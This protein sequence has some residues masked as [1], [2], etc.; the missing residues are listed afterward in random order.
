[1]IAIGFAGTAKNTGKTTTALAVLDQAQRAGLRLG[2]T[3]IGFDGET[4][5]H[6]TGLPK[7]RYLAPA[8]TWVTSA[9]DVLD[10]GTA[11]LQPIE[12]LD[13]STLFGPVVLAKVEQPGSLVLVGPN[14]K[15]GL[16]SALQRLEALGVDLA[17]VDGALNRL[18]LMAVCDGLVLSTG[19]AYDQRIPVIADHAYA[20]YR[21]F[22]L[23]VLPPTAETQDDTI[24]ITYPGGK[25]KILPGN[26]LLTIEAARDLCKLITTPVKCLEIPGVCAPDAVLQLIECGLSQ[27][28]G[29]QMV[30]RSTLNLVTGKDARTW[31]KV[32][33]RAQSLGITISIRESVP[34]RC[35]TVNPIFPEFTTRSGQ[36][37]Y[38]RLDADTLIEVVSERL[39]DIPV[40]NVMD[41][42]QPD[43]L[44]WLEI[45]LKG[46]KP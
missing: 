13:S 17:L 2:L 8:G 40:V 33:N 43:L 22:H 1:M 34:L 24:V 26:S 5:D 16:R 39:D 30:F 31:L 12:T 36:Y 45:P 32:F 46:K 6:I 27:L 15:S 38:S 44:G 25:T 29:G 19:A 20:L 4:V 11:E 3:S 21:L 35:V 28:A 14:H 10:S 9:R 41:K 42:P 7:P 23:P 37:H 18:A